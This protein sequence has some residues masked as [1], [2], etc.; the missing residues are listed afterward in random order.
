MVNQVEI[1][2]SLLDGYKELNEEKKQ[3]GPW[4]LSPWMNYDI[5]YGDGSGDDG[6][7]DDNVSIGGDTDVDGDGDGWLWL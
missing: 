4:S 5:I 7:E 3:V 2:E 1:P 6:D